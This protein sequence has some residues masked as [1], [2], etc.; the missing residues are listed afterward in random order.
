MITPYG[1][2]ANRYSEQLVTK[3]VT[4]SD[5]FGSEKTVP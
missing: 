4:L 3:Q 2:V 5:L 1:V